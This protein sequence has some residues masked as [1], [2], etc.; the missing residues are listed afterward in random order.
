[1]YFTVNGGFY[2]QASGTAM[3]AAISVTAANVTVE[4]TEKTALGSFIRRLK[5]FVRY[6][7]DCFYIIKKSA[8]DSFL[9]HRPSDTVHGGTREMGRFCFSMS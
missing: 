4:H 9:E 8:V 2:S 6:V 7:D 1:M 3:G 5:V